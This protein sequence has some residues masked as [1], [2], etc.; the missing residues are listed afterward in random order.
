MLAPD[1]QAPV[2]PQTSVRADL[3]QSL[4]VVAQLAVDAVGEDLAVLAV[5]DVALPVQEPRRDL[6]LRWVL[7]DGYDALEFFGCELSGAVTGFS[8]VWGVSWVTL[9]CSALRVF[10]GLEWGRVLTAW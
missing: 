1:P 8:L 3:L 4:Q 10:A 9:N 5:D 6:V 2:V 7:D